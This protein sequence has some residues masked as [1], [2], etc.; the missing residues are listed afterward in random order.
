M[1]LLGAV[2][3]LLEQ[4]YAWSLPITNQTDTHRQEN[5]CSSK[6]HMVSEGQVGRK[7]LF[8]STD[9]HRDITQSRRTSL[10]LAHRDIHTAT[11]LTVP[12]EKAKGD[13]VPL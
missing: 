1:C 2:I 5:F 12:A 4:P 3:G 13:F 8:Q 11:H 9:S 6:F 7:Q 10:P